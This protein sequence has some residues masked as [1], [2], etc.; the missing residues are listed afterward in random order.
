MIWQLAYGCKNV[1]GLP[2]R[3]LKLYEHKEESENQDNLWHR[4]KTGIV[5][6]YV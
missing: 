6:D 5:I 1:V 3:T 2:A 4:S